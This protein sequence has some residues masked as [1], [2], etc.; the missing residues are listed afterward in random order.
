MDLETYIDEYNQNYR[1]NTEKKNCLCGSSSN[2]KIFD[3]DRY[4]LK[5]RIVVCKDCGL[6]FSNPMLKDYFLRNFYKSDFYRKLYSF[7]LDEIQKNI[8]FLEGDNSTNSY[9]LIQKFLSNN[10][11]LNI[12]EIGSGNNQNLIHYRKMGQLFAIDYSNAS[13]KSAVELGIS[14]EQG[15]IS[16][17]KN[18]AKKFDIIILSHVIEHFVNFKEDIL[19]IKKFSHD[20]TII[21]IEVPSMDLKYNLD[22]L[23]NAHNFYFTKNTFLYHLNKLGLICLEHGTVS[24]IHQYGVFKFGLSNNNLSN[25]NEYKRIMKIHRNFYYNFYWRYLLNLYFRKITKKLI[26]KKLTSIIKKILS[27]FRNL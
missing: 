7:G 11:N 8:F 20:N 19:E 5:H 14:F 17:I 23:Q 12:L 1:L 2:K 25:K 21:Y 4:L 3:Y 27:K 18:F 24:D 9:N 13:K 26:G 22:Q 15:G 6:I 10:Q 16:Q